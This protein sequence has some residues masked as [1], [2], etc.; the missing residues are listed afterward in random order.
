MFWDINY[1]NM[2]QIIRCRSKNCF[3]KII[4]CQFNNMLSKCDYVVEKKMNSNQLTSHI[5]KTNSNIEY[6][7]DIYYVF[8]NHYSRFIEGINFIDIFTNERKNLKSGI[9]VYDINLNLEIE[10]CL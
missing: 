3:N 10:Y 8:L 7:L 6:C 2:D 9:L 4:T 1:L 5:F